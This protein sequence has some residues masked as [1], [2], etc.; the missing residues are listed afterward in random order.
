MYSD[1]ICIEKSKNNEFCIFCIVYLSQKVSKI[2]ANA[3]FKGV[4]N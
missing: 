1:Q 4:N 2:L 3:S